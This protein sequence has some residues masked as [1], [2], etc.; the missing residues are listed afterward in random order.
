VHG[1]IPDIERHK[2]PFSKWD[3]INKSKISDIFW[4]KVIWKLDI[5]MKTRSA[6]ARL[7]G[8]LSDT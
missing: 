3:T 6:K 4:L 7:L 5:L 8:G 2:K 1:F